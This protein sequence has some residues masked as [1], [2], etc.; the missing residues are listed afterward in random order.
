MYE[1]VY[2]KQ[3]LKDKDK[4]TKAK[5]SDNAKKLVDIIEKRKSMN[6]EL[7]EEL[8]Q[9]ICSN[10]VTLLCQSYSSQRKCSLKA[11]S[12]RKLNLQFEENPQINAYA[13]KTDKDIIFITTGLLKTVHT[14]TQKMLEYDTLF[15]DYEE[16][17]I[18]SVFVASCILHYIISHEFAH[19]FCGHFDYLATS[20]TSVPLLLFAYQENS[21]LTP[22]DYQTLEMN[23]DA[24]AMA[25]MVSF[26]TFEPYHTESVLELLHKKNY[27]LRYLAKAINIMFFVLRNLLPPIYNSNYEYHSHPPDFLRQIM[28]IQTVEKLLK[29]QYNTDVP[30]SWFIKTFVEDERNLC[31][32]YFI[33]YNP[34]HFKENLNLKFLDHE[35]RL[36]KNW[37]IIKEKLEPF[38]WMELPDFITN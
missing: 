27:I 12:I 3:A 32:L 15:V 31:D 22:L 34:E 38:T 13:K 24:F 14:A 29:T 2:T 17:Q 19:L 26:A 10:H 20:Q 37:N 5:L 25:H 23:A 30:E 33:E 6:C 8:Y 36:R 9:Q 4:L 11:E 7:L 35:Q 28:N 18:V 1:I 21:G 16:N